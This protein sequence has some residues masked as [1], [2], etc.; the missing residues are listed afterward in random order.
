MKGKQELHSPKTL[1]PKLPVKPLKRRRIRLG[2]ADPELEDSAQ[3]L[4]DVIRDTASNGAKTTSCKPLPAIGSLERKMENGLEFK[5]SN[6]FQNTLKKKVDKDVSILDV[7]LENDHGKT[8]DF[9][10]TLRPRRRR[11]PTFLKMNTNS[12]LDGKSTE[13]IEKNNRSKNDL[14]PNFSTD[15]TDN[16]SVYSDLSEDLAKENPERYRRNNRNDNL[17]IIEEEKLPPARAKA[18]RRSNRRS[19]P[20]VHELFFDTSKTN[21]QYKFLKTFSDLPDSSRTSETKIGDDELLSNFA[22]I[23]PRRFDKNAICSDFSKNNEITGKRRSR[24]ARQ[25]DDASSLRAA[26]GENCISDAASV[27]SD[28]IASETYDPTLI[29][30]QQKS[31]ISDSFS[32]M[33]SS[34]EDSGIFT[35]P[36]RHKKRLRHQPTEIKNETETSLLFSNSVGFLSTNGPHLEKKSDP[37]QQMYAKQRQR[38]RKYL[39]PLSENLS[40]SK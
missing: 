26:K 13:F 32:N 24:R 37:T 33:L 8:E 20:P 29:D 4:L 28:D 31:R 9:K 6:E 22:H 35:L 10:R 15:F 27:F 14:R 5:N 3:A 39:P 34:G 19:D 30:W 12:Q 38:P 18:G 1:S 16:L 21:N 2:V 36:Q 23:S 11:E 17:M 25:N 7:E 40:S